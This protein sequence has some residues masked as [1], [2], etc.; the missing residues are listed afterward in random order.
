[1]ERSMTITAT[2][3]D[4]FANWMTETDEVLTKLSDYLDHH[5]ETEND[6]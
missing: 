6:G 1:M 4:Q 3:S 5:T 2:R